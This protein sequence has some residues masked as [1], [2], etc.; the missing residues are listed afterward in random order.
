MLNKA[1]F[2][3]IVVTHVTATCFFDMY[4]T[5][6]C[7]PSYL[8]SELSDTQIYMVIVTDTPLKSIK[9]ENTFNKTWPYLTGGLTRSDFLERETYFPSY[10]PYISSDITFQFNLFYPGQIN[11]L[12]DY[13]VTPFAPFDPLGFNYS[14]F[15]DIIDSGVLVFQEDYIPSLQSLPRSNTPL[16]YGQFNWRFGIYCGAFR[17]PTVILTEGTFNFRIVSY[18]PVN[19]YTSFNVPEPQICQSLLSCYPVRDEI[20]LYR[21]NNSLVWDLLV[22]RTN[23]TGTFTIVNQTSFFLNTTNLNVSQCEFMSQN[24]LAQFSSSVTPKFPA[25]KMGV[26]LGN[27]RNPL[28]LPNYTSVR[29]GDVFADVNFDLCKETLEYLLEGSINSCNFSTGVPNVA[30]PQIL[31][32]EAYIQ[33]IYNLP[34][35][36]YLINVTVFDDV[37]F[38]EY[39]GSF[40]LSANKYVL[41]FYAHDSPIICN[42]SMM[43]AVYLNSS[44]IYV[45]QSQ[46]TQVLNE[47]FC[48]NEL[49][50]QLGSTEFEWSD[51]R[52]VHGY[53]TISY[54]YNVNFTIDLAYN[55]FVPDTLSREVDIL[56][57]TPVVAN[58]LQCIFTPSNIIE[59]D[60]ELIFD[61]RAEPWNVSKPCFQPG[62]GVIGSDCS[63]IWNGTLFD[64]KGIGRT[65]T[66]DQKVCLE[67]EIES[68]FINTSLNISSHLNVS[69][70]ELLNNLN[71]FNLSTVMYLSLDVGSGGIKELSGFKC[72]YLP[73]SSRFKEGK[74]NEIL[75]YL[76]NISFSCSSDLCVFLITISWSEDALTSGLTFLAEGATQSSSIRLQKYEIKQTT[77]VT[78]NTATLALLLV[79]TAITT[80]TFIPLVIGYFAIKKLQVLVAR[81]HHKKVHKTGDQMILFRS[82]GSIETFSADPSIRRTLSGRLTSI[83]LDSV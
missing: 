8:D 70:Q 64:G 24:S 29:I 12:W 16:T 36:I 61:N 20:G 82:D 17:F 54:Y 15:N 30:Y 35:V 48:S 77:G 2:A 3:C 46:L 59:S 22:K 47:T 25:Q 52:F 4:N 27:Q 13:I 9:I 51:F 1:L 79:V 71:L 34:A 42:N 60:C 80:C 32:F 23:F 55:P 39:R 81:L 53:I 38:P 7:N 5:E 40:Q 73:C 19:T 56:L 10:L 50:I 33:T 74:L 69:N 18:A 75:D 37:S 65:A 43:Y 31:S 44:T 66:L 11:N 45:L 26:R 14:F 49:T 57:L 78:D 68:I 28:Q 72:K 21:R 63:V 67:M 6:V 41:S 83:S 58:C 62:V 76:R